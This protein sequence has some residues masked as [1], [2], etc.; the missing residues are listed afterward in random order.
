MLMTQPLSDSF[1]IHLFLTIPAHVVLDN[2][3][4]RWVVALEGMIYF[5]FSPVLM[6][7]GTLLYIGAYSLLY[8]G[9][10]RQL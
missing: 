8:V 7:I 4:P 9:A 1:V 10:C 5:Q 2:T 6:P 3:C